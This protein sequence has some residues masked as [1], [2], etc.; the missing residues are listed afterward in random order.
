[1]NKILSTVCV[2]LFVTVSG[3]A[4]SQNQKATDV[5][6]AAGTSVPPGFI[7]TYAGSSA[8]SGWVFTYGQEVSQTGTYAKL[9]GAIGTTYCV[10]A[11]GGTCTGG[12]FRIPDLRGKTFGGKDNM[13]G[14]S[15]NKMV[16]NVTGGTL[17]AIGGNEVYTPAGTIPGHYHTVGSGSVLTA[18]AQSLGTTNVPLDSGSAAGQSYGTTATSLGSGSC[19]GQGYSA[20]AVSL[21]GGSAS[22]SQHTHSLLATW[23]FLCTAGSSERAPDPGGG[24]FANMTVGSEGSHTHTA[25]GTTNIGHTH[26]QSGAT[27]NTDISHTHGTS[28]STGN[29]DIDHTN[30]I[31][32]TTGT[33][34]KVTGGSDGDSGSLAL[35]G[36]AGKNL[37]PLTIT[38][39]IIKL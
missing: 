25:S 39:Y 28:V 7:L 2:F 3:M 35:T 16:V 29:T 5:S 4:L 15:A 30:A 18:A 32:S 10:A 23:A 6:I 21:V 20:G 17:G 31:S 1:M 36:T 22:S 34:G 33:I 37:A 38:N 27:G 19:A 11:H 14:S 26:V 12:N 13:G 9:Y 8:P 24:N